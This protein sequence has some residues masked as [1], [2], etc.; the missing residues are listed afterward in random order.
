MSNIGDQM[1]L[2]ENEFKMNVLRTRLILNGALEPRRTSKK[3]TKK[4][5]KS[6][7]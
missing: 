3:K 2:D 7:K 1:F 5:K 4:K 6:K